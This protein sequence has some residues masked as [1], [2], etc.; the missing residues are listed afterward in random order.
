MPCNAAITITKAAVSAD[1]LAGLLTPEVTSTL[2][3]AHLEGL[4]LEQRTA[5]SFSDHA[6]SQDYARPL[7]FFAV[8]QNQAGAYPRQGATTAR[9]GGYYGVDIIVEAGKVRVNCTNPA[10]QQYAEQIAEQISTLMG[11]AADML[12]A[13]Q[14]EATM[15][16]MG[17]VERQE[18]MVED[19]GQQ[20]TAT[21]LTVRL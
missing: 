20:R 6:M 17:A 8:R 21:V 2:L 13:Q 11:A 1:R 10:Q 4:G 14:V 9:I 19:Q 16:R 5:A 12:F 3:T 18:V 7:P 15:A